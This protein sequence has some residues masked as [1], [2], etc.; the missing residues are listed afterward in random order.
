[1]TPLMEAAFWSSVAMLAYAYAGFPVLVGLVGLWR[2]RDVSKERDTPT[3]SFIVAAYNEEAVIADRLENVL[4]SDYPPDQL[5]VIVADDGST[6]GTAAIVDRY[7]ERGVRLLSFPRRGKIPALN[8]AVAQARGEILVFSDANIHCHRAAIAAM[9]QNFADPRVGGVAGHT[10]YLVT[11]QTESSGDGERLYWRYDT[12]LK[13]LESQTG[14]VVS[15]HGGLYA[16]RRRLYM[17]VTDASVTDDFAI[18]T[19]VIEQ[20]YRLVFEPDARAV[21]H[22]TTEA[23][24]EMQRRV[25]LMTR[26]LRA[27]CLRRRLLNPFRYGFYAVS[28]FSHKVL[29]RLAPIWL[30]VIALATAVLAGTGDPFFILAGLAQVAF[31][32]LA[33]AGGLLR[34]RRVGHLKPLCVPFYYCM[35]NAASALALW[36]FVRGRRISLWQPQRF[37]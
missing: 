24:R 34:R 17:T 14:S 2:R 28:L 4:A 7:R 25:R 19:A 30:M 27:V 33:I 15:A 35:A 11:A 16:V 36:Q 26:G 29:R 12:W 9:M 1:V 20:G 23:R 37:A 18:S 10:T 22:T 5:E 8:D 13:Q 31:Y 32:G 6:D 21:E 3:V